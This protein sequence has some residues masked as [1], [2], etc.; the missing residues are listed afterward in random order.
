MLKLI[1][2]MKKNKEKPIKGK[3]GNIT[4]ICCV[5]EGLIK[6]GVKLYSHPVFYVTKFAGGGGCIMYSFKTNFYEVMQMDY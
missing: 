1:G 2:I 5:G 4:V 3:I 6:P